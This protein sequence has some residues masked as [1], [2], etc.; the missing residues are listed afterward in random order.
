MTSFE[1]WNPNQCGRKT[2]WAD[3]APIERLWLSI[4]LENVC[5]RSYESMTA[6][7]EGIKDY[8]LNMWNVLI[9]WREDTR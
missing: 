8:F 1:R 6:L 3:N 7:R 5:L 2:C 4:K 9:T